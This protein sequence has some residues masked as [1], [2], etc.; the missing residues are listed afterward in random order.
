MN[1]RRWWNH[2][3]RVYREGVP[4]EWGH[5]GA[6]VTAVGPATTALNARPD[7]NWA[8]TLQDGGAGELQAARRRW[9][10]AREVEVAERDILAVVA[11]PEAGLTLRIVSVVPVTTFT[12]HNHTEV[13]VESWDGVLAEYVPPAPPPEP[14]EPDV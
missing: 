8:G 6:A 10:L 13:N 9:F 14:E 3:V 11:G 12:R 2:R 4:D 7:Q 1:M 5:V